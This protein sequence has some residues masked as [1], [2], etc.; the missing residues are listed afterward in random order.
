MQIKRVIVTGGNGLLGRYIS[1]QRK[2]VVSLSRADLDITDMSAVSKAIFKGAACVIH[3]AALTDV[4]YCESHPEDAENVNAFGTKNIAEA[5]RAA[6]AKLIYLSTD[7]VF[8][9]AKT[10]PLT[11]KHTGVY[12]E[13]DEP[14][15]ISIYSKTKLKGEEF[16]KITDKW[17]VVRTSVVYGNEQGKRHQAKPKK[18]VNWAIGELNNGHKIRAIHDEF[19]S[20]TFAGDLAAALLKLAD[21]DFGGIVHCAGSERISRYDFAL[22][23]ADVFG[24]DKSLIEKVKSEDLKRLA[25]RPKDSSLDISKAKEMGIQMSDASHG[26]EKMREELMKK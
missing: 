8:D 7:F 2:D 18:F 22:K 15:P 24:K 5:C 11:S 9:G 23:I 1:A 17:V 14:N 6:G 13:E 16:A 26:L 4:D 20:P 25:R 3:C 10:T 21:S 19:N 12:K